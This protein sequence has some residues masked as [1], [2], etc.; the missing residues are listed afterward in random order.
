[1]VLIYAIDLCPR[2]I[3]LHIKYDET[4]MVTVMLMERINYYNCTS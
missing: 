2:E 1:M 3:W 4:D